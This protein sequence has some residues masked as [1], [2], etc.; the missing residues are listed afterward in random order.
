MGDLRQVVTANG[1][2]MVYDHDA[3]EMTF[4]D[5]LDGPFYDRV[6]ASVAMDPTFVPKKNSVIVITDDVKLQHQQIQQIKEKLSA[7]G[8]IRGLKVDFQ[9]KLIMEDNEQNEN[10]LKE[11]DKTIDDIVIDK[12][13]QLMSVDTTLLINM[14]RELMLHSQEI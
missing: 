3:D 13:S 2:F 8:N 6:P 7:T 1:G 4:I 11:G 9:K 10:M 12:L 14:Y 5:W